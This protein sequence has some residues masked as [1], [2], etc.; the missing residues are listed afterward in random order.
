VLLDYLLPLDVL[1]TLEEQKIT[2]LA[3]V[4]PLWSQLAKLDWSDAINSHLRYLTNSGGK[5][6]KAVLSAIRQRVPNGQF[7]LMYGLTEAFR[8]TYLPPEQLDIRPDSIGKAILM[9]M[10]RW[11][12][13]MARVVYR[14]SKGS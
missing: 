11:C 6:P 5:M 13:K 8:S 14:M 9:P 2:G 3:C 10:Y 7:F 4:P 1:N 12:E